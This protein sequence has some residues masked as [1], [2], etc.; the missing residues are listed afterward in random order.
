MTLVSSSKLMYYPTQEYETYR[1]LPLLFELNLVS[2]NVKDLLG[3]DTYRELLQKEFSHMIPGVRINNIV[4]EYMVNN[5]LYEHLKKCFFINK[6]SGAS[7]KITILDPFAGEG[8]WLSM[9]KNVLILK[10]NFHL[11]AN[12]LERNR[13]LEC[14]DNE[15]IDEVYN[16]SF[17]DFDYPKN[18]ISLLLFNPPY[19]ETNGIR[20]VKHY[21]QMIIDKQILIN[22]KHN[23]SDSRN[24]VIV[25]VIRKDDAI[26]IAHLLNKYFSVRCNYI[27]KF[28]DAEYK[29]YKQHVI[30]AE[31]RKNP[32]KD[33]EAF[34]HQSLVD[35]YLSALNKNKEYDLSLHKLGFYLAY[36][37]VNIEALKEN[38]N[39]VKLLNKEDRKTS[40]DDKMWS[41]AKEE[42]EVKGE[43]E[44]NISMPLQPKIG[45]V[46]NIIASGMINSEIKSDKGNH[47]VV[48]GV[49]KLKSSTK[50]LVRDKDGE[51]REKI[52]S[53]KY[54]EPYV[55][56]LIVED[57]QYKIKELKASE[58]NV[59]SENE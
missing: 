29:K 28:N 3:T 23:K 30:I 59:V 48:G 51:Y 41:W 4:Y 13:Y 36:P 27:Y 50:E 24:G 6:S 33:T 10:D 39:K 21:L 31:L 2:E 55:N 16:E 54:N 25:M 18:S 43:N 19:E 47:V 58:N 32:L 38:Y 56:L 34:H 5:M 11:I 8:R 7:E 45:E 35:D 53:R 14:V 1:I 44:I 22:N 57:G 46:A 49:K 26:D 20:N 52:I 9:F 37:T 17:E 15:S 42:T 40:I 12:E